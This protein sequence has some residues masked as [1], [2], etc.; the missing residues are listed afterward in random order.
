MEKKR[1]CPFIT[2]LKKKKKITDEEAKQITNLR[3]EIFV[4]TKVDEATIARVIAK[5][6]KYRN[7]TSL[8]QGHRPPKD[9][10]VEYVNAIHDLIL[11][12]NRNSLSLSLQDIVFQLF[13]L[14]FEEITLDVVVSSWKKCLGKMGN[15][16][17]IVDNGINDKSED[18][19][20][21]L[22][23]EDKNLNEKV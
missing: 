23:L 5:F 18:K 17:E 14:G 22:Y 9:F 19:D 20:I 21:N 4:A 8:E 15:Y 2:I 6:N 12:A 11:S 16:W 10:Q 7:I 13:E 1:S 3:K